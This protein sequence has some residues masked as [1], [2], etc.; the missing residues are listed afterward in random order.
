ML[1]M[2]YSDEMS[3]RYSHCTFNASERLCGAELGGVR[4]QAAQRRAFARVVEAAGLRVVLRG[5]AH[6]LG[7]GGHGVGS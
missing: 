1:E 2:K 3:S 6:S 5:T 4:G 7:P